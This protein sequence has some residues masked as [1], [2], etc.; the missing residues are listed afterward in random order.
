M[1]NPSSEKFSIF[2]KG[3]NLF[4]L[5]SYCICR[6]YIIVQIRPKPGMRLGIS[7]FLLQKNF[8]WKILVLKTLQFLS[9]EIIYLDCVFIALSEIITWFKLGPDLACG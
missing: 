1:E 9:R 8:G 2:I 4:R 6:N 7:N 3:D 5:C